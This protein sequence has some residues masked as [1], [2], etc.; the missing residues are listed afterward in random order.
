VILAKQHGA[1]AGVVGAMLGI[2]AAGG[3]LGAILAPGLQRRLSPRQV[4]IGETWTFALV[5]PLLLVAHNALLFGLILATAELMTPVTNSIVVSLRVALA[6]DRLQSRAQGRRDPDLLLRRLARSARRRVPRSE[7]G[8]DGYDPRPHGL[9]VAARPGRD[10]FA[11]VS[12]STEARNPS[13]NNITCCV[14][15]E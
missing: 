12:A 4:L 9:G 14:I 11:R 1:S 6:P 3:L 15:D 10:R 8:V 7:H 2:A 5:I 13:A